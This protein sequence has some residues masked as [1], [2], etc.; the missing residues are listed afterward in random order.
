MTD[1]RD[2]QFWID[3]A[4]ELYDNTAAVVLRVYQAG[5]MY[6]ARQLPL[7]SQVLTSWEAFN[8]SAIEYLRWY[9]LN[10][11]PQINDT[12]R[13]LAV[14]AIEEW[15]R[16]GARFQNLIGMLE[17]IF[18]ETRAERIAVTEVTRT[19]AQ[20]N[21]SAWKATGVVTEKV[22]RTARDELVCPFCG[23]LDGQTVSIDADFNIP[24][25]R[26]PPE[27]AKKLSGPLLYQS[28]PAHPNCRCYLAPVVSLASFE[29]EI[30]GALR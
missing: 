17:P 4:G 23:N 12:T 1:Y 14:D 13:R 24:L 10:T 18:G 29:R 26:L 2:P 27:I 21:I 28:P 5:G 11:V 15:I 16:S 3:E 9:R 25:D 19:F 8:R 20:G 6:A 22:W 7:W 30:E